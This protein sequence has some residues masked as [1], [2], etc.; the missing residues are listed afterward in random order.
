MGCTILA[1]ILLGFLGESYGQTRCVLIAPSVVHVDTEETI[2]VSVEGQP[3]SSVEIKVLDFPEKKFLLA[4]SQISISKDNNFLGKATI[5]IPSHPFHANITTKQFVTINATSSACSLEKHVLLSFH[6]GYIFI[7]TDKPIYPP[8]SKVLYRIFPLNNKM[9]PTKTRVKVQLQNPEGVVVKRE[10][11]YPAPIGVVTKSIDLSELASLGVWTLTA[12]YDDSTEKFTTNFE[13]KEYVLPSFEVTIKAQRNFIYLE[14][15]SFSVTINAQ[16]LYGKPVSGEAFVLF[17]LKRGNEEKKLTDSL[18]RIQ[19][20]DGTGEVELLTKDLMKDFRDREDLV[21]YRLHIAV[22]VIA[23]S[24]GDLVEAELSNIVIVKS[25]YKIL[26]TRTP[27]YFKPGMPFDLTV[28]VTNPDGSPAKNIPVVAE[29]GKVYATTIQDGTARIILDTDTET[30]TLDINVK[31]AEGQIL[32]TRQASGRLTVFPYRDSNGQGNYLHITFKNDVLERGE[33]VFISFITQNRN[34]KVHD[35]K[36]HLTY[37]VLSRGQIVTMGRQ[38]RGSGQSLVTVPL[39]ITEQLL[40][41]FRI[42]AY[43]TVGDELVSDSLWVDVVDDCMGTLKLSGRKATAEPG[44][45]ISLT[46]R[47]DHNATVVLV[48]VD[49][50]VYVMNNNYR[51]TQSKMWSTVEDSDIGCSPGSGADNMGVFYDAGL[52]VETNFGLRTKQRSDSSCEAGKRRRRRSTAELM[53]YRSMKGQNDDEIYDDGTVIDDE[54]LLDTEIISRNFFQESWMWDVVRMEKAPDADGISTEVLR[55]KYLPDSVTTWEVLAISLSEHKG[56]CVAPPYE[57]QAVKNFFI[58][59]KLPYSVARNEQV[60]IRAIVYNYKDTDLKVRISLSHNPHV[61]SLSTPTKKFTKVVTVKSHSSFSVPIVIVPLTVGKQSVEVMANVYGQFVGDGVRK[62]LRVVPEGVRKTETVTSVILDPEAKGGEHIVTIPKLLMKNRVPW[63]DVITKVDVQGSPI[64]RL[65]VKPI[66]GSRLNPLII[67]PGGSLESNMAGMTIVVIATHYLNKSNQWDKIGLHRREEALRNIR[68][69]YTHQLRFRRSDGSYGRF[70]SAPPSTWFTAHIT[71]VL[72]MAIYL[73]DAVD[74]DILCGSIK[75]LILETQKPDGSFYDRAPMSGQYISGGLYR[76]SD[77][78]VALTAFVVI[79]LLE[80]KEICTGQ[81]NNLKFSI[82]KAMKYLQ[83]HHRSLVRPHTIAI[84]SYALALGGKLK[85]LSTLVSAAT[86][87]SHW[88]EPGSQLISLEATSYALLTLL[89]LKTYDLVDPVVHWLTDQ[90]FYGAGFGSTQAAIMFFQALAKYQTVVDDSKVL[91][92]G[93][94]FDFQE[95]RLSRRYQLSMAL[96][97]YSFETPINTGF[98]VTAQGQGQATLTVTAMYYEIVTE[99]EKKCDNFDLSVTVKDE[100]YVKRPGGVLGAVSLTICFRHLKPVNTTMSILE[101]SM[102]TGFSPDME[103]LKGLDKYNSEFQIHKGDFDK[104]TVIIYLDKV[105]HTEDKCLKIKA[106][107]HFNVG[108]VQPAS[109]TIYDYDTPESRC[110]KFYHKDEGDKLLGI[111]CQDDVCRCAEGNCLM[112]Q[113]TGEQ[114]TAI[115]RMDKI[116]H[117][118]VDHVYKVTLIETRHG[119]DYDQYSMNITNVFKM[120]QD[121]TAPGN[122]RN[123]ISPRN[124]RET[125][126]LKE[127]LDYLV[128]GHIKD[129]WKTDETSYSYMIGSHTWIEWWPSNK[130]CQ[131]PEYGE[132][133]DIFHEVADHLELFG[134]DA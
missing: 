57:I 110:T 39:V 33:K 42:V 43:Y 120:G 108:L 124:C 46:L 94:S 67:V 132:I 1:L 17:K 21:Q 82:D 77:P 78:E 112:V 62:L 19:I 14:D 11:H 91:N 30:K 8:A 16:Y 85:D 123:F 72:T 60:E 119:K 28:M 22:T 109:V 9:K 117:P 34:S 31:T 93:I 104:E 7:Q 45:P 79:A 128:Y 113:K 25:P 50:A 86:D 103:D 35:Q 59:L 127:G 102:M 48:A 73:V 54:Y 24:G 56:I 3:L 29:P 134:C 116:C 131:K 70:R 99:K 115:D 53:E 89:H 105:S 18:R 111:I 88:D 27:K 2:M 32:P 58:D 44:E 81:V 75:W 52:A 87:K 15:M 107:Q 83:D 38:E 23:D 95:R 122:R 66:N 130:Q 90:H 51:M 41:S 118:A 74:R 80:S 69:G 101:I 64:S 13:V 84:T 114:F 6:S 26:F 133:C 76:S 68:R 100:P 92:M 55:G 4:Q 36:L 125:L 12:R 10:E 129:V 61:C 5:K 126:K 63:S 97:L 98:V 106:H 47:A 20:S 71:K 121:D 40:P 37:L 49:K 65:V 96:H